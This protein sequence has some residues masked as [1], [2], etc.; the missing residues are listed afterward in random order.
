MKEGRRTLTHKK[1]KEKHNSWPNKWLVVELELKVRLELSHHLIQ[2]INQ[3]LIQ[4]LRMKNLK[5][6]L[7]IQN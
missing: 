1:K 5:S 4:I 2:R 7:K 6:Q 3:K